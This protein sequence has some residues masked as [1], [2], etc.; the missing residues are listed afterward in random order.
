MYGLTTSDLPNKFEFVLLNKLQVIFS[1]YFSEANDVVMDVFNYND[2]AAIQLPNRVVL[3]SFSPDQQYEIGESTLG[4][5]QIN[6]MA[7]SA[8]VNGLFLQT[9]NK[10]TGFVLH[11]IDLADLKTPNHTSS[12]NYDND[13]TMVFANKDFA[14]SAL[15]VITSA[16]VEEYIFAEATVQSIFRHR[17]LPGLSM[18]MDL[19]NAAF[20]V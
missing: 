4:V 3:M 6:R 18:T 17:N 8:A 14:D 16:R 19:N 20:S 10:N 2:M 15:M 13:F 1:R 11:S 12:I 7:G 9:G 5:V